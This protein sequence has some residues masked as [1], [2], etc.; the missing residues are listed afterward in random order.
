MAAFLAKILA[1]PKMTVDAMSAAART[2]PLS[3]SRFKTDAEEAV[4]GLGDSV[5][6][7]GYGCLLNLVDQP[8]NKID[9][10]FLT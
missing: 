1:S 2:H 10:L 9:F 6:G 7:N 8:T 5:E 4:E 3:F